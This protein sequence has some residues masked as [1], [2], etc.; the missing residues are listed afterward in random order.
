MKNYNYTQK[1]KEKE[2]NNHH[3]AYIRNCF[4]SLKIK[5]K[6]RQQQKGLYFTLKQVEIVERKVN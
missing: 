3:T 6:K 2:K 4:S 1:K 5:R